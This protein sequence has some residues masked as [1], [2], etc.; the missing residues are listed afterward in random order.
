MD[1]YQEAPRTV[2]HTRA[3]THATALWH[4]PSLVLPLGRDAPQAFEVLGVC[5]CDL[6]QYTNLAQLGSAQ[7][8]SAQL[9]AQLSPAQPAVHCTRATAR[10]G[11]NA[12]TQQLRGE[13][14]A[15]AGEPI[16]RIAGDGE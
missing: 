4:L 5:A 11:H 9:P 13:A 8:S 10:N 15:V 7:L 12:G 6:P 16:P 1:G 2:P 3:H 14:A